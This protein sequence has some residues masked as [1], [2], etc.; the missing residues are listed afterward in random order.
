MVTKFLQGSLRTRLTRLIGIP[1][2]I[3]LL[4]IFGL[5]ITR[6]FRNAVESTGAAS[7]NLARIH[8]A[9]LDRILAE[10]ARV[11]HMHARALE[12]G[13]LRDPETVQR[14]L[15]DVL[16]K[17]P[18]IYG[19]CL[20]FEPQS[21]VPDQR[22]YC[23]YAYRKDGKPEYVLLAP[24]DYDHFVWD[25]YQRPKRL[26]RPL[27]TEPFFDEGGGNVVMTTRAVPFYK[28]AAP[29][30]D[31][32]EFWGVATI[33]MSLEEL[34][35]GLEALKV[36]ET[37][38]TLLI[39]P[40]GRILAC[41]DKSKIMKVGLKDLNAALSTAM[42][43]GSEGFIEAAD[44]L[45]P[46]KAWVAYTPVPNANFMLALVY[47]A[48]EVFREAHR[49][50]Q[51]LLAIGALG[52]GLLFL[53]LSFVARSVTRPISHL[54]GVARK[55]ADGDLNQR[56]TGQVNN[57]AEVGELTAAFE[58]MTRD[59]R[60]RMEELKYTT[61]VKERMAG[62]L[63]AA[64]RIQMSML[65]REW[66]AASTLPHGFRVSL[67]AVIQPAREIGG[68]FYDYRILDQQRISFLVGDVSGKGVPAALFM[69]MTQTLFKGIASPSQTA[70]EVMTRVNNALCDESH[71]GMFV[72]L[73]YGVLDHQTGVLEI[74]NAGHLAPFL[75]R[76]RN[77][78]LT[79]KGQ[80]NPALGLK[81]D[82]TFESTQL[83]LAPGDR[84]I[85]YTDGVTEA[86]NREH[87]LYTIERLKRILEQNASASAQEIT[88]AVVRD[89]Q[90]HT[91]SEEASDDLTV[92][93]LQ[94]ADDEASPKP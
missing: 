6:T 66:A 59:L 62:E 92:L 13:M 93:T 65:P 38:Y 69:A 10:A 28:P 34:L 26:A 74:C 56:L 77:S 85:L 21:F 8:A 15:M 61:T 41:P 81:R 14:Y 83:H 87:Q 63:S 5:V 32:R 88:A 89:V 71:T 24:P 39:S 16:V 47:P 84:L 91:D 7:L 19:S 40:E 60:M 22:N 1:A 82:M 51:E 94:M 50:L 78:T 12:S 17:T 23:P 44:P 68:D 58:K 35:T 11:P 31:A 45:H 90:A 75:L 30:G 57:I 33:D 67:H 42:R 29:A 25:W 72:T 49:L 64:R 37:G 46:R 70:A 73:I 20:A 9:N 4:A 2:S 52:I 36:A 48:D 55:I 18:N 80:R 79:L 27:W 76:G 3:F 54:A 86:L 43:P 53:V